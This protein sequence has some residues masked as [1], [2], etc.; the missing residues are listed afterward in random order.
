[1]NVQRLGRLVEAGVAVLADDLSLRE[2]GIKPDELAPG[3]QEAGIEALVDAIVHENT[4]A[5]WH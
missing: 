4:K 5:L 1:M 2:R 3:V